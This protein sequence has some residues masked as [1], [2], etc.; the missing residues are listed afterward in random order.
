MNNDDNG[1]CSD[2]SSVVSDNNIIY[3][4]DHRDSII[5]SSSDDSNIMYS[6]HDSSDD[7]SIESM[8][9][10]D[11]DIDEDPYHVEAIYRDDSQ[12]FY[13]EKIDKQ[14][15]IGVCKYIP[16]RQLILLFNSVSAR[17]FLKHPFRHICDYLDRTHARA[18]PR[19]TKIHIMQLDVLPDQTYSVII[20]THWLRLIQRHWKKTFRERT[21]MIKR[22]MG[23]DCLYHRAIT[24]RYKHGNNVLPTIHGMMSAYTT[25]S[26]V[27][28]SQ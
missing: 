24:G 10:L 9:D 14:Y 23:I 26:N 28:Y 7:E 27:K 1:D 8:D 2:Y 15:Y 21:D 4:E 25:P 18:A 5:S 13:E 19:S 17:V 22:R 20:K 6:D 11:I 3:D 12:H 16:R